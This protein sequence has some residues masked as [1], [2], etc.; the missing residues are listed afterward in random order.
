MSEKRRFTVPQQSAERI[1]FAAPDEDTRSMLRR[2][3]R[4]A[5]VYSAVLLAATLVGWIDGIP[6]LQRLLV[7]GGAPMN[8]LM[9]LALMSAAVSGWLQFRGKPA[10]TRRAT[11]AYGLAVLVA[12]IGV[13]KLLDYATGT[14]VCP[15]DV[16]FTAAMSETPGSAARISL[17]SAIALAMLGAFL[18][19]VDWGRPER[20]VM[21]VHVLLAVPLVT[22]LMFCLLASFYQIVLNH[23]SSNGSDQAVIPSVSTWLTMMFINAGVVL[24]RPDDGQMRILSAPTYTGFTSRVMYP[25]AFNTPS[26]LGL[27]YVLALHGNWYSR[28]FLFAILVVAF[29]LG[30]IVITIVN[31]MRLQMLETERETTWEELNARLQRDARA[32]RLHESLIRTETLARSVAGNQHDATH[33]LLAYLAR[34]TGISQLCL[35]CI[36]EDSDVPQLEV[37]ASYAYGDLQQNQRRVTFGEGAAGQCAAEGRTIV[38]DQV[39]EDYFRIRSATVELTPRRLLFIPLAV[40][41]ELVGVLEAAL[42]QPLVLEVQEFLDKAVNIV[43]FAIYRLRQ[44]Q[45]V[46]TLLSEVGR[47][48]SSPAGITAV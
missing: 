34:Q 35:F 26:V 9:M 48:D 2:H 7:P 38:V 27:I 11:V 19:M 32:A 1:F 41:G 3:G 45:R 25:V 14:R 46:Q 42:L 40:N 43:A 24:S 15:D 13:L 29:G 6:A 21:H 36:A 39:P 12:L 22:L 10:G 17:P 31:A 20:T 37:L 33:T 44:E 4:R 16:L 8:P 47:L 18:L 5:F 23:E 28:D 30:I